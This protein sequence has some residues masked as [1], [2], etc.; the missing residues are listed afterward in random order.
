MDQRSESQSGGSGEGD[1]AGPEARPGGPAPLK[2]LP[3]PALLVCP[4]GNIVAANDLAIALFGRDPTGD[5]LAGVLGQARFAVTADEPLRARAQGRHGDNVP[6][7][8]DVSI[9]ATEWAPG[10]R[11]VL[12]RELDAWLLIQESSRLLDLAFENSPI[13]LGVF[14]PKGEYIRVNPALCR[15]LDRPPEGLI[16]HRDQEFTHADD[17]QSDVDA[18]WRILN[19]EL[20]VWQ[21]EKRF[22]RPDGAV[23]W[24]I[25]NMTFLR[26]EQGH[27]VAWMGQFQDITE[28]KSLEER[29]R[30]LA[31]EDP[32]TNVPNRRSFEES[33]RMTLEV[34]AR[35]QID[36]SLLMIDLDGFKDINDTHGHAVGDR[37]LAAVASALRSRL[38]STDLLGR[39]GGDEFAV[40][41]R[42]TTG[43]QALGVASALAA[44]VRET[45]LGAGAPKVALNASV[46]VADFGTYPLP[47]VEELFA[48]A[49]AAM[50]SAKRAA[51]EER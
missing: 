51:R 50:Y 32:L 6:F 29:L 9:A 30:R 46:G 8:V 36:G 10:E 19:G 47:T 21:T 25:A 38:R 22:V 39:V 7:I 34:S 2:A 26:D 5:A 3:D 27:A 43:E 14:N 41:L 13:G 11:L 45:K 33:V 18:A 48:A 4:D 40:L 16:G 42:A 1:V 35:H 17:R 44:I 20:D 28:R 24:A 23:V 12:L 37:T 15:L 31:D 49:D